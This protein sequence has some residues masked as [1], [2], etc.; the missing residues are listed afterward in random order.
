[1]DAGRRAPRPSRS[2]ISSVPL[3]WWTSQSRIRTRSAPHSAIAC[4]AA[5]AT[6]LKRQ[7]PI[8]RVALGVVPGR[9]Q[10]RRRRSRA[11]PASSALGR[12]RRRRRRRAARPPRSPRWRPCRGRSSR[13]RRAQNAL[14]RV[15]QLRG[16]DARELLAGRRA[17]PRPRSSPSQSRSS[18]AASIARIRRAFSGWAPVSCSS[19][20]GMARV[21]A[22]CAIWV[23]YPPCRAAPPART[24]S[25]PPT[26]PSSAAAPP[27]STSRSRRPR[28]GARVTLVSRKPLAESASFWAQGGLAAALARRRLARAPRRGHAQRRA[29]ALPLG[30]VEVLTREAPAAVAELRSAAS[31]RPDPDGE[32][33][34]GLEGGHSARR[35]VHAGGARPAARSPSGSPSSSPPSERIEVLE[36]SSALG[37]AGATASAAPA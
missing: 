2:K 23:P 33:A 29:R 24:P 34:L 11:S 15:D 6:L 30:A 7:K 22:A 19:E 28:R 12:R 4:A 25:R 36:G 13:R 26:S 35:I 14:D 1:M 3:P 10:R 32:L 31:I 16:V 9:A 20:D 21:E 8:A 5:T 17:A 27:A 37:A 18:S